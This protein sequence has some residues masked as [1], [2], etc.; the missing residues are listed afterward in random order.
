MSTQQ[1]H[2]PTCAFTPT[3][4]IKAS[5]R[6]RMGDFLSDRSGGIAMVFAFVL[7][8]LAAIT[9][10][11][12]DYAL[13]V[14]Q[15]IWLQNAIDA[16]ALAAAKELSLSDR[17]KENVPAI[18]EASVQS[19]MKA[20]GST[21]EPP[22]LT[23]TIRTSPLEVEIA[24]TQ[25]TASIMSSG[26]WFRKD[27][28]EKR[29]VARVVG[30]PNICLLALEPREMGALWLVKTARMTGNDCS[31]FSNS[32]SSSGLAVRDGAQLAADSI[33]SA[34]GVLEGGEISPPPIY[35]W[36][37]F[38]DPLAG[39]TEP[40]IGSCRYTKLK[41]KDETRTLSPGVYCGGLEIS[42]NSDVTFEPGEYIIKDAAFAVRDDAKI[43]G[44]GASFFLHTNTW[45]FFGHD[46][47]LSLEASKSGSMAGLL[48]FGARSQSKFVTHTIL[49]RNA[50]TLVGTIYLP[51]N[52]F[53]VDGDANV[54]GTS[55]Y[56]AI[57]ARRVVLLNGPHLVLN[58]DYDKTDV[59]V[60]EGIKGAAQPVSLVN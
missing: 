53:I 12:I 44:I 58:S 2:M 13:V 50:Q 18:V 40:A 8:I 32:E 34:G 17:N 43:T 22:Q 38:E 10:G 35:D 59:P 46:T 16:A 15:N 33:C 24:A 45:L 5:A 11:A 28:I 26:S 7:P 9:T 42:G 41:I 39:R 1:R 36:P 49:S 31:I 47:T 60:P 48:F 6:F 14:R 21:Y 51:R 4:G 30:R 20:N 19:L 55:A 3:S 54:G 37:Q 57:V 29:S 52:S 23:T 27:S 25:K 56:T